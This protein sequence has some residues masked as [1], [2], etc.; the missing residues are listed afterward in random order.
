MLVVPNQQPG[1]RE[2]YGITAADADAYVWTLEPATGRRW[3]G[4]Q[5]IGR[6]FSELGGGWRVA[7]ALS[8]LPGAEH[9]YRTIAA[10]RA[11]LSRIWGDPPPFS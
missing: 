7:A 10:R 3:R 4:A 1:M 6:V 2:S 11:W 9:A 5:A 8:S